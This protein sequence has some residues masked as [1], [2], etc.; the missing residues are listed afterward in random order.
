MVGRADRIN[1][2]PVNQPMKYQCEERPE[3]SQSVTGQPNNCPPSPQP[4]LPPMMASC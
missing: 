3:E 2:I 1:N 4:S